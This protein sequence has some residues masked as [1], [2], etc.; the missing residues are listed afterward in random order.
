MTKVNWRILK[1]PRD[2]GVA[3]GGIYIPYR[4]K[5]KT[6]PLVYPL[7]YRFSLSKLFCGVMHRASY[8]NSD[9]AHRR[10]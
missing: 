1:T 2:H 10:K 5:P 8:K 4:R 7:G 6:V 3:L 9:C